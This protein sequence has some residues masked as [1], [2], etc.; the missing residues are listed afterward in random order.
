MRVNPE[1]RR[2]F[3]LELSQQR[4]IGMPMVLGALFLLA[5]TL[6]GKSL[7]EDVAKM[8]LFLFGVLAIVWGTKLAGESVVTEIRDRT[9][10]GQRMSVIG[11][12]AMTWGKL[13]G[14]TVFP[15]YGA[16][17]CLIVYAVSVPF[18]PGTDIFKTVLV[19]AGTGL[20]G[21][22]V[23]LFASLLAIQRDRR[24]S[25]S[26]AS[27]FSVLGLMTAFT[28]LSFSFQGRGHIQWY[29]NS[30]IPIDFILLSLA[31]FLAW[32]VFGIYRL[33]RL[34]LQMKNSPWIWLGFVIFLMVYMAGFSLQA[35]QE[36]STDALSRCLLSAYITVVALTYLTAL[37]EPKDP[38][39]FRRLIRAVKDGNWRLLLQ[40]CPSWAMV[41]PLLC[42][43]AIML[44]AFPPADI[45]SSGLNLRIAVAASLFFILRDLALL[46]FFNLSRKPKRADMLAML[47]LGLLWLVI[48]LTLSGL[49]FVHLSQLF[50]FRPDAQ[51][52]ISL[53]AATCELLLA[54]WL[55]ARRWKANYG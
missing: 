28:V 48:P 24:F 49:G 54:A 36:I 38:I 8:S 2:N 30:F 33:M 6:S 21:Q 53:V 40:G 37:A 13:F 14:S 23:A 42:V 29:G 46:L 44:F 12:W 31:L 41:L 17:L 50:H 15:W 22:S 55:V 34:E 3:W 25:R 39:R 5:F 47:W 7:G 4:L 20:A 27:A 16:L 9:W 1:F 26:Q 51:P 18:K 43:S 32:A 35:T 19:M 10:D 11:P 52:F 45:S